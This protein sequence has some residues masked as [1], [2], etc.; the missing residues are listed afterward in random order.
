MSAKFY[1]RLP[2]SRD[3]RYHRHPER[4][5]AGAAHVLGRI[6]LLSPAIQASCVAELPRHGG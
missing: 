6:G 2:V 5:T 4:A 1:G 3:L